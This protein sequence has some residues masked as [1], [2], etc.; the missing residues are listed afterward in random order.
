MELIDFFR[1]GDEGDDLAELVKVC[2]SMERANGTKYDD[3]FSAFWLGKGSGLFS[4]KL[5]K[6]IDNWQVKHMVSLP[7]IFDAGKS[8]LKALILWFEPSMKLTLADIWPT[9]MSILF[10]NFDSAKSVSAVDLFTTAWD[11]VNADLR[12]PDALIDDD[13]HAKSSWF[14][15]D[16]FKK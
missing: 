16:S 13:L 15:F 3:C 11:P 7:I 14:D 4:R 8:D 2:P 9:V 5:L 12:F 6:K 1:V 10:G